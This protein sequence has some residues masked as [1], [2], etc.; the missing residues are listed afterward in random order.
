[1]VGAANQIPSKLCVSYS[2]GIDKDDRKVIIVSSHEL[3]HSNL[4][5]CLE[6]TSSDP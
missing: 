6:I 4:F 2:G 1:M 3:I 5:T